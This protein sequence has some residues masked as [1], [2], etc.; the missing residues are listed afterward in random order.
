MILSLR[1]N[2][3]PELCHAKLKAAT[4][5]CR[6]LDLTTKEQNS[7]EFSSSLGC[8]VV[9]SRCVAATGVCRKNPN[10]IQIIQPR[11]DPSRTGEK[12]PWVVIQTKSF[13]PVRVESVLHQ[14]PA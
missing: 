11:V 9:P 3:L 7:S 4:G 1:D 14:H 12:L 5:G 8:L 13:N 6:D 10:G 2:L